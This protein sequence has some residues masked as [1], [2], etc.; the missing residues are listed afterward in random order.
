M[1][2]VLSFFIPGL[3]HMLN[4][5]IFQGLLFLVLVPV[6]YLLSI[7]LFLVPGLLLHLFVIVDAQRDSGRQSEAK[8]N[9]QAELIA[10]QMRQ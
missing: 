7:P 2:A 9:R 5:R 10:R 8:M 3:G 4:G 6:G 1:A